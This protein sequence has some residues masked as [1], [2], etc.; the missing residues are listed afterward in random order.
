[1]AIKSAL[2][3]HSKNTAKKAFVEFAV[4]VLSLLLG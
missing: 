4:W 1:M 2:V 3:E